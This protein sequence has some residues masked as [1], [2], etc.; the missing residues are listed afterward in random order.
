[1]VRLIDNNEPFSK[2]EQFISML[3]ST[4]AR[5]FDFQMHLLICGDT[6]EELDMLK[7]QVRNYLD[8]M[9]MRGI[10]LMF[11]QEKALKSIIPIFAQESISILRKTMMRLDPNLGQMPSC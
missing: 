8:A 3:A 10:S 2:V 1:M 5:I 7:M 6:K 4:Q 9:G 11:E